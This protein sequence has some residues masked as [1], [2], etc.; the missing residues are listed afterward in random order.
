LYR[1]LGGPQSLSEHRGY[2]KNPLLLPDIE[3]SIDEDINDKK[4]HI[5]YFKS[6]DHAFT[7]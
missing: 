7:G 5:G 3:R 1:R 6:C 4:K 2:R